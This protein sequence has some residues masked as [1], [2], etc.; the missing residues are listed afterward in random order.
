MLSAYKFVTYRRKRFCKTSNTGDG[1]VKSTETRQKQ[2]HARKLPY[3]GMV[4]EK[5]KDKERKERKKTICHTPFSL[6]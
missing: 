1:S 3:Y 5:K 6:P 4:P 2:R